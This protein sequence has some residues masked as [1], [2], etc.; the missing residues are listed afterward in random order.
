MYAQRRDDYGIENGT[1]LDGSEVC[2]MASPSTK[3]YGIY[4][5]WAGLALAVLFA[6]LAVADDSNRPA[7]IG[8]MVVCIAAGLAGLMI[9]RRSTT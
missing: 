7:Y 9:A 8:A 4:S 3:Q 1:L 5:F 6:I 2:V